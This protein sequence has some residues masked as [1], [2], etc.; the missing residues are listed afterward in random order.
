ELAKPR[1]MLLLNYVA[2]ASL[3]VASRGLFTAQ[4]L[5]ALL[6]AGSLA[7]YASSAF[8]A[9]LDRDIDALMSRTSDRPL[10]SGRIA[11]PRRVL[12]FASGL[13]A[14]AAAVSLTLLNLAATTFIL[15][16]LFVYVVMYTLWLKRRSPWNIVIGGAAGSFAALAGWASSGLEIGL[17]PWLMAIL[18]FLWTPSHFWSLA[19]RAKAEYAKAKLPM[20]PVIIGAEATVRVIAINTVV[21]IGVSL[22]FPLLGIFGT[23]YLVTTLF[24]TFIFLS[25]T[26]LLLRRPSPERAWRAFKI[27][28]PYLAIVFLGMALD[29]LLA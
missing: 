8:N 27:S 18:V 21:L 9:Y 10:P 12:Y 13:T 14:V 29:T 11:N 25:P 2:V 5:V 17:A 22:L 23:V 24:A 28:S 7:S 19:L 4:T 16:G 15:L 3:I 26:V 20:L 6:A 1:I